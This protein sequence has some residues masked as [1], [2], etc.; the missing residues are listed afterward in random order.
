VRLARRRN[1]EERSRAARLSPLDEFVLAT[2]PAVGAGPEE[3]ALAEGE[4]GRLRE[5]IARLPAALRETIELRFLAGKQLE[6][7]ARYQGLSVEGIKW[8]LRRALGLLR[9]DLDPSAA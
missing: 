7:I 2:C 3:R 6:E 5:C 4:G 1:R 9:E 8:R